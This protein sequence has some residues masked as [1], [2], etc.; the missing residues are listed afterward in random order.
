[1]INLENQIKHALDIIRNSSDP[2]EK[3]NILFNI[4][5]ELPKTPEITSLFQ[6]AFDVISSME[7][8]DERW[9][10]IFELIKE[11]PIT[12]DFFSINARAMEL[13]IDAVDGIQEPISRKTKLHQ[14][15]IPLPL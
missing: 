8:V 2:Q 3:K 7:Q 15:L 10:S 5:K 4:I 1:M 6:L 12:K 13:A 14:W 11:I 9:T